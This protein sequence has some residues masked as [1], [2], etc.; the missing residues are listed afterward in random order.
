MNFSDVHKL[1]RHIEDIHEDK[2]SFACELCGQ[3]FKRMSH[4]KSHIRRHDNPKRRRRGQQ[5]PKIRGTPVP[6]IAEGEPKMFESFDAAGT[7][8][9]HDQIEIGAPP[10]P[11]EVTQEVFFI[12]EEPAKVVEVDMSE[13]AFHM[14][15]L[16]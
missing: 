10:N 3:L 6:P 12:T 15:F 5:K 2:R 4:L 13:A 1:K 8:A 9:Q 7:Q 16:Q 11:C 14:E